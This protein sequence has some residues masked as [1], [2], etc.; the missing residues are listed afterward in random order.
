MSGT[1][2]N[3]RIR[4]IA[5]LVS[6]VDAATGRQ[7]LLHLPT[8][9]AKQVRAMAAELGPVSAEEKRRILSEFQRSAGGHSPVASSPSP[10]PQSTSQP[11]AASRP[12]AIDAAHADNFGGVNIPSVNSPALDPNAPAWTRLSTQA[13][14]RFVHGERPAVI[15]VVVS[16]LPPATAVNVLQ[17]L[18]QAMNREVLMRLAKLGEIDREAKA[19]IDEYLAERLTEYQHSLDSESENNRRIDALLSAAPLA[20]R[21]QWHSILH[22]AAYAEDPTSAAPAPT[23][24][25]FASAPATTQDTHRSH[26]ATAAPPHDFLAPR[27]N[28][29]VEAVYRDAVI[30]TNDA[31]NAMPIASAAAQAQNQQTQP[32]ASTQ[33]AEQATSSGQLGESDTA[34]ILPFSQSQSS[35]GPAKP[36]DYDWSLTRLEFERIVDLPPPKLAALLTAADTQTVLLA[37]AGASPAFMNRFYRMLQPADAN[38][39]RSRLERIGAI[40]L[41]DIDEAQRR[42]V[43]LAISLHSPGA[44]SEKTRPRQV[45]QAA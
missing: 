13:L 24:D 44:T 27:Q 4:Q 5:I 6:S 16:Q 3:D 17:E 43:E 35:G 10:Q 15:A 36:T 34:H 26:V 9:T 31:A 37:L 23:E 40:Q 18:P 39:L 25:A 29:S 38:A 45:Q 21:E 28:D 12:Q 41:R 14:L 8:A 42:V 2:P 7:L 1:P 11:S 19:A 20:I 32:A 22:P 33:T 30:T